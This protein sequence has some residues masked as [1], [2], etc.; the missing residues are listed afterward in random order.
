MR[1]SLRSR[2]EALEAAKEPAQSTARADAVSLGARQGERKQTPVEV[3]AAR[4][5]KRNFAD[6]A[7]ARARQQMGR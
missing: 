1:R 7:R 2:T 4:T 6:E 5:G 3:A